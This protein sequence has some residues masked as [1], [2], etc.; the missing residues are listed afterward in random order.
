MPE[1]FS[2]QLAGLAGYADRNASLA[3]AAAPR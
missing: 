1:P 2:T 3:P